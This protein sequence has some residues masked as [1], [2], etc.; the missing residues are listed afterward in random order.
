V[1]W[2]IRLSGLVIR[3]KDEVTKTIGKIKN[4]VT[5]LQG[6]A[7]IGLGAMGVGALGGATIG[8]ARRQNSRQ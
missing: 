7:A 3:V 4:S 2:G 8:A 5:S 6:M 1:S